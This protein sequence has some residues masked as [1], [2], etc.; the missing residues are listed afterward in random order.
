MS[1]CVLCFFI[2]RDL[3]S[4]VGR[5]IDDQAGIFQ[6]N[7]IWILYYIDIISN[8]VPINDVN[9]FVGTL[10]NPLLI[11]VTRFK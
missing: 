2:Q 6:S 8:I 7:M 5:N 3:L 1:M 11:K 9:S 10:L 4:F